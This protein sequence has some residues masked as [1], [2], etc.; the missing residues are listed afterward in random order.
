MSMSLTTKGMRNNGAYV[1]QYIQ[2]IA[3]LVPAGKDLLPLKETIGEKYPKGTK[4]KLEH[5]AKEIQALKAQITKLKK[6]AKLVIKH[7][8]AYLKSVSLQQR[9]LRKSFS[10][11]HNV[12]KESPKL[13]LKKK[14]KG[15]ELKMFEEIN[16]PRPTYYKYTLTLKH[17]PRLIQKTK[18]EEIER[19]KKDSSKGEEIKQE[20]KDEVKEEDKGEEN[21]RKRKHGTRKK[22]KSRKEIYKTELLKRL[23]SDIENRMIR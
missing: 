14:R 3:K 6:Q 16:R 19:N 1:C 21:T 20:S 13:L 7:H 15:V 22:M 10:K 8:K 5:Q 4:S 11:K 12:H 2:S 9:F 17:L 18:E 23:P